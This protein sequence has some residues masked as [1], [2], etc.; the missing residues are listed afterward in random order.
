MSPMAG[1]LHHDSPLGDTRP[2]AFW[3]GQGRAR[4]MQAIKR[5]AGS[6]TR[7][8]STAC[9]RP[10]SS[11]RRF[12]DELL[13]PNR[14][15]HAHRPRYGGRSIRQR[16]PLRVPPTPSLCRHLVAAS[17]D[18][19][20]RPAG[21]AQRPANPIAGR[22]SQ[23]VPHPSSPEGCGVRRAARPLT[24]RT[25]ARTVVGRPIDWHALHFAAVSGDRITL[26]VKERGA[27]QLGTRNVKRLRRQGLIPGVLYGKA[28]K[29]FVVGERELR[30][31]LTGPSGST[32]SSTSSS[33]VRRPRTTPC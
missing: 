22:A 18:P 24:V 20:F 7:V 28:N 12:Y 9:C 29:A 4:N 31:A 1:L 8:G 32:G 33:T 5:K 21:A 15:R 13:G 19:V 25:R 17:Q 16:H 30:I 11:R 10:G 23:G 27:D 6:G 14:R 26:E 3:H 2:D